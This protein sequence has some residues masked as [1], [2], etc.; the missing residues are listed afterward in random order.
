MDAALLIARLVLALVFLVAGL[1]KLADRAGTRRGV[2]DFGVPPRLVSPAALLLPLSE[3]AVAVALMPTATAWWGAV[4]ALVLLL[5]FV[6]AIGVNLARGR[7]PDCHCFG[8]VYSRPVGPMTLARNGALAAVAAFVVWQGFDS[9]GRS[10]VAWLGDMSA[11]EAAALTGAVVGLTLLAALVGLLLNLMRQ[12]GRLLVRIEALEQSLAADGMP[13]APQEASPAPQP[14]LPVGS[15]AP[16]FTL[17]GLHGETLTLDALRAP[18]K[19]VLLLLTDP[20]CGPC[21]VLLP[22]IGRWQREHAGELTVAVISRGSVDANRAK[23]SEHGLANVLLQQDREVAEAYQEEGTPSAV[24]VQADGTIGSPLAAGADQIRALVSQTVGASLSPPAP[25]PAPSAPSANGAPAAAAPPAPTG[26]QLGDPAPALRLP[27]VKG[28]TVNLTGFRGTKTL[29]LFWN[30]GC[31]FCEQMLD[32]LRA[33]DANPPEGA[34]KLLVVATGEQEEIRAMGLRS[35]ILVDPDFTVAHTFG[36][37]GT[38]MAV[39]VDEEGRIASEVAAGAPAVMALAGGQLTPS[40]QPAT[41]AVLAPGEP[42]PTLRLP[43]AD[44]RTV[45]LADFRGS[46]TV[47]L[48][49][50]PGCGFCGQMLD[51]LRA[52]DANRPAEAP[53]LVVVSTGAAEDARAMGL[54]SPV[55][56]D[57][58]FTVAHTFGANGTPMAVLIDEHGNIASEVAVGAPAVLDLAGPGASATPAA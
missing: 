48:F 54:R 49:W 51:D 39:L 46:K 29:V 9:P 56:L 36:A 15:P 24:V 20:N 38:P 10:A 53:N 43:D 30:P 45:D 26:P 28:R 23:S 18:G 32:D 6:A 42:A 37:N 27:D 44:G 12:H 19:P 41:P 13:I 1:A 14:G 25:V 35:P 58:G 8:Q 31:G 40:A 7:R 52:F 33:W 2:E 57:P 50:N 21:N 4:G 11:A 34:P 22:D 5:V 16:P 17:Q 3:L 55:L 47:L